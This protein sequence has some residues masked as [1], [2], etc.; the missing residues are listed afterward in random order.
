MS[1]QLATRIIDGDG[2]IMEDNQGIIAHMDAPYREIAQRKGIIFPP[3]DHLHAGRAVETPPQ[4]DQRPSVGPTGWLDFLDDV[5]IEWTVLY[6]TTALAYGKIVSLDYAVAV[7]RAYND[8]RYDALQ[9]P[10]AAS[11]RKDVLAR[12]RRGR[13]ARLL[14]GRSWRSARPLRHGSYE[15]VCLC[16]RIG[17][18]LG[19][20]Y[21]LRGHRLQRHLRPLSASAHRLP[22]RGGCVV[23]AAARASAC[24]PRDALPIYS[25]QRIRRTR[26]R[27]AGRLH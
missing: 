8:W 7:S 6:P 12:L 20:Y 19:P 1:S 13:S 26:G 15:H 4:R 23:I 11:G 3:L 10:V 9:R 21:Q 25:S 17:P 2:H 27:K 22:R 14:L 16:A 18:S 24:V 5:G